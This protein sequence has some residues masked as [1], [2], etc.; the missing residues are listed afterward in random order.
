MERDY[1]TVTACTVSTSVAPPGFCN[2]GEVRYGSTIGGLEYEVP[3]KLTHLLQ[4]IGN[5]YGL[6]R[7]DFNRLAVYLS[8]RTPIGGKLPLDHA[9]VEGGDGVEEQLAVG[10]VAEVELDA[11]PFCVTRP[12]PTAPATRTRTVHWHCYTGW[13]RGVV[14]SGVRRMNEVNARWGRLV[15][16]WVT[17]F[18]RVYHL[19]MSQAN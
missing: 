19:G 4:C 16:G 6:V 11:R 12:N 7:Y 10:E 9:R 8:F 15:P 2:R 14:V 5:L 18:G 3:Q 1:V 17:V 13:R